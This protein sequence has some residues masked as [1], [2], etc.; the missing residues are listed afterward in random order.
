MQG[1]WRM[2][3][4]KYKGETT[5]NLKVLLKNKTKS[6]IRKTQRKNQ[7]KKKKRNSRI[8]KMTAED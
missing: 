2:L 4:I 8:Q 1:Q 6:S 5:E 3:L 7:I